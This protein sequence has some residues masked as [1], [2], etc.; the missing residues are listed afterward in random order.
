VD[1]T[2]II[3]RDRRPFI[4]IARETGAQIEALWFDTPIEVCL[5]RN[6]GRER[7]VPA[8]VIHL[9]AARLIPPSQTEGFDA[10]HKHIGPA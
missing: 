9:M 2:N 6:A 10:V 1:A 8:H 3:R 7:T 5:A 4:Q